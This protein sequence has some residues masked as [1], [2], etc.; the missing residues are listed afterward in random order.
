MTSIEGFFYYANS[1]QQQAATLTVS[2]EGQVS[3]RIAEEVP[4][5]DEVILFSDLE[6]SSRL[7]NTP[8]YLEF[9]NGDRFETGD[10]DRIDALLKQHEQARGYRLLHVLE[11]RVSIVLLAT[12]VT[13]LFGHSQYHCSTATREHQSVPGA[14][15]T[16]HSR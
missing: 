1:S 9:V 12:V 14:G 10:N 5:S 4:E 6:I 8:R 2:D 16:Q 3:V 11:S 7:G 13:I 15:H